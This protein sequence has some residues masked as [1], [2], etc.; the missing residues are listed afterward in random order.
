[1]PRSARS[2]CSRR[3]AANSSARASWARR[4]ATRYAIETKY[5]QRGKTVEITGLSD[6]S[7][8]LHDRLS[9]ELVGGH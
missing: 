1:M 9:G 5:A 6:P 2:R 3:V 4:P 8:R 7:A